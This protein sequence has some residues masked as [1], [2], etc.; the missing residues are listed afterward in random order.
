MA[1]EPAT[2]FAMNV[3][4]IDRLDSRRL[5]D[6]GGVHL[7]DEQ[8]SRLGHLGNEFLTETQVVQDPPT[9]G[10]LRGYSS[11]AAQ[12]FRETARFLSY[13]EPIQQVFVNELLDTGEVSL[14]PPD[15][16]WLQ[17]FFYELAI[18][19]EMVASNEPLR[20][21]I[22]EVHGVW[23]DARDERKDP[24]YVKGCNSA[25][26]LSFLQQLLEQLGRHYPVSTLRAE[27]RPFD[28]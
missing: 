22:R 23:I 13:G 21:L 26:F 6:A 24:Y 20:K 8:Y 19:A 14:D 2:E 4:P 25:P 7:T 5:G 9:R 3:V 18:R 27:I 11:E 1:R 16:Q 12:S 28:H 10:E 15:M 17:W